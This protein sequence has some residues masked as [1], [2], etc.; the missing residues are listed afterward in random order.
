[1]LSFCI[2]WMYRVGMVLILSFWVIICLIV[3]SWW[4]LNVI[5]K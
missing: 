1:M 4:F 3:I 2:C 5:G